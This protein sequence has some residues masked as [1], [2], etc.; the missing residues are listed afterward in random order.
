[1]CACMYIH[2]Q[3]EN[4]YTYTYM[5]VHVCMPELSKLLYVFRYEE[6]AEI[7]L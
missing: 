2:T 3:R 7:G 5:H 6:R 1:M 4:K